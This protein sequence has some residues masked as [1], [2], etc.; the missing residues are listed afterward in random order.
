MPFGSESMSDRSSKTGPG[1]PFSRSPMPFGS[2]SMSDNRASVEA[3]E[4]INRSPM[5][6]GS[7]SMSDTETRT[8]INPSRQV[9]TNAFRQ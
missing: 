3:Y 4:N 2:E 1:K 8:V 5:P 6:F 9:V 7:E